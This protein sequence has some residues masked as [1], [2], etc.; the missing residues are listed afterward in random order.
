MRLGFSRSAQFQLYCEPIS[1]WSEWYVPTAKQI[2]EILKLGYALKCSCEEGKY[3]FIPDA[4]R[5]L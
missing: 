4:L 5:V 3:M 2:F 1:R